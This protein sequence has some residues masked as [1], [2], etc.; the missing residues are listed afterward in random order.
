MMAHRDLF[1]TYK[2]FN[3]TNV[4]INLGDN[5]KI[6]ALGKGTIDMNLSIN[7]NTKTGTLTEVLHVPEISKNLFSIGKALMQ[8]LTLQFQ[9]NIVTFFN[10]E[11]PVMTATCQGN[12]YYINGSNTHSEANVAID[13]H[14]TLWHKRLRHIGAQNLQTMI[15]NK[16]VEGLPNMNVNLP[17]CDNYTMNKLTRVPFPLGG[18]RSN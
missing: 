17:F 8:G 7:G 13:N 10:N 12:M 2:S 18:K 1:T 6:R 11:I 3:N 9:P 14:T 15:K 5:S 16:S 4:K